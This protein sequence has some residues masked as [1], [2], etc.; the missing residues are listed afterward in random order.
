MKLVNLYGPDD[1]RLDNV[2]EPVAGEHDIVLGVKA[3]GICGS[4]LGYVA[5][6]G[7]IGP[8]DEP[9]PL[10]HEL[11]GIVDQIGSSVEGK[12]VV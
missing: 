11:S 10:G 7:L 5:A 8:G 1:F 3:C 6:G 4:D 9:M 2:P 12:S